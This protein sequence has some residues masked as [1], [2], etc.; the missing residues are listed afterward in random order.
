VAGSSAEEQQVSHIVDEIQAQPRAW[1]NAFELL[2]AVRV[3]LPQPGE[4]VAVVGCG[5]SWFMAEAV[6]RRREGSRLGE[7][8]HFAASEFPLG[9]RY[10]RIVAI[11]RSGT[12]TEVLRLLESVNVPST[13]I[14]SSDATPIAMAST[15]SIALDFADEQSVVQTVF[16]TTALSLLR[17]SMGEP[18]APIIAEAEACLAED[19]PDAFDGVEQFTFLGT[20]WAHGLAREAALKMREAAQAWT[21]SYPQMEYR[22][23]PVAIA[24]PGRVVWVFGVPEPGI[25]EDATSAGATVVN[26]PDS[27]P[28]VDLIRVQRLADRL[29]R[30]R[31]L[32]PDHPRHLTRSVMLPGGP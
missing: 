31:G 26:H 17:A 4:R 13:A 14:T 29:A 10:D 9:R 27:D 2:P 8:D 24:Q 15:H 18:L 20:G 16:A 25:V 7:T 30:R 32:D 11:S 21:E 28:M 3:A 5:T 1:R 6:A 22:H 23:G 12:T 19:E